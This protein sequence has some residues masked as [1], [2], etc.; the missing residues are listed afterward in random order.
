M[1]F[2][3]DWILFS[4]CFATTGTMNHARKSTMAPNR[5]DN[6]QW[7]WQSTMAPNRHDNSQW[8]H[9]G[10]FASHAIQ[11]R[12]IYSK[13][14]INV[15]GRRQQQ[16]QR[17]AWAAAAAAVATWQWGSAWSFVR[18]KRLWTFQANTKGA[19]STMERPASLLV[20]VLIWLVVVVLLFPWAMAPCMSIRG[21][22]VTVDIV[23]S[24]RGV[25][26]G[27]ILGHVAMVGSCCRVVVW[28]ISLFQWG[29]IV[30]K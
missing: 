12:S 7:Q 18:S 13:R 16:E 2:S 22:I 20:V 26:W 29:S 5:H 21:S 25:V 17:L 8:Q 14:S 27:C 30:I 10:C 11:R 9:C 19:I 23:H 6:S 1:S 15:R 3:W 24:S 4:T 28:L